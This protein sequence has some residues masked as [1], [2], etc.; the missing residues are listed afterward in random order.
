MEVSE[1]QQIVNTNYSSSVTT[2]ASESNPLDI[3]NKKLLVLDNLLH[4][5]IVDLISK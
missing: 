3:L 1:K 5:N 4:S 2:T